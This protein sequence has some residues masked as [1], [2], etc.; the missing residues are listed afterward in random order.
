MI[1]GDV[2]FC[3][4]SWFIGALVGL[5][6]LLSRYNWTIRRIVCSSSGFAYLAINGAVAALAYAAA[7]DSGFLIPADGKAEHWRVVIVSLGAMAA[8]RSAF[9][10]LKIGGQDFPAGFAAIVDIFKRRAER[11]L[12]QDVAEERIERIA[13]L[14]EGLTYAATRNYLYAVTEGALRSVSEQEIEVLRK[15]FAKIDGLEVEDA[16]KMQLLAIRIV[17]LTSLELFVL[18]AK[19]AQKQLAP[20]NAA[21]IER[22]AQ[23]RQKFAAARRLFGNPPK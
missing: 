15:D 21:E 12:D 2:H 19:R 8:F 5:A 18:F 6:E 1:P 4:E 14:V 3:I 13:P 17:E 23:K 7:V 11:V 10:H 20:Q 9:A 16:T 22:A